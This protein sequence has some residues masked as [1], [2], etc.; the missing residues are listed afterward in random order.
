MPLHPIFFLDLFR[1]RSV[2]DPQTSA[3]TLVEENDACTHRGTSLFLANHSVSVQNS[4]HQTKSQSF[5]IRV[6]ARIA[7]RS[8]QE[9]PFLN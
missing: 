9:Y 1:K 3:T 7:P 4:M 8:V 6:P 5:K 2:Q